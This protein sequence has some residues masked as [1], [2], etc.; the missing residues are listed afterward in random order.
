MQRA[1]YM[2]ELRKV[3]TLDRAEERALWA[4]FKE[5]GDECAR[6]RLIE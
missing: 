4:A 6:Q 3:K 5:R 2:K 1:D